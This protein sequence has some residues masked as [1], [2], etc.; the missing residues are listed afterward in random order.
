MDRIINEVAF[1]VAEDGFTVVKIRLGCEH[2]RDD[3]KQIAGAVN[4]PLLGHLQINPN[5]AK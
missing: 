1:F 3:V 2:V 5:E 4:L